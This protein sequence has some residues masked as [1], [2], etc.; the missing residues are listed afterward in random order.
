MN[1]FAATRPRL[2]AEAARTIR[3][4]DFRPDVMPRRNARPVPPPPLGLIVEPRGMV[5][6]GGP[7]PLTQDERTD[8]HR[9]HSADDRRERDARRRK[10]EASP[11]ARR[12]VLA[13]LRERRDEQAADRELRRLC[14][15]I[16]EAATVEERDRAEAAYEAADEAERAAWTAR[17]DERQA[18]RRAVRRRSGAT[19]G[20]PD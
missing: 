3:V 12:A 2:Q 15:A 1:T 4:D 20:N 16:R 6:P 19:P 13:W 11:R 14:R 5:G 7:R 8:L 17:H 9:R 10:A 18:R